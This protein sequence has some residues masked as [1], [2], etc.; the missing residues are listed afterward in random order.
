[1][2]SLKKVMMNNKLA[3]E[4]LTN[5]VDKLISDQDMTE[6]LAA[7]YPEL[8]SLLKV[9]RSISHHY[10]MMPASGGLEYDATPY[11]QYVTP[12]DKK[13]PAKIGWILG[14][15]IIGVAGS[16]V[17]GIILAARRPSPIWQR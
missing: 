12:V 4:I 15:T 9:A 10:V 17:T 11:P 13:I 3:Q 8:A 7:Q 14:M 6:A 5:H 2:V 16:A 1:M